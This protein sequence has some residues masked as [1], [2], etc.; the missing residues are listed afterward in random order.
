MEQ[1]NVPTEVVVKDGTVLLKEDSIKLFKDQIEEITKYSQQLTGEE[2]RKS[3]SGI[4]VKLSK[5]Q[6]EELVNIKDKIVH[7]LS[8]A[9][10][11]REILSQRA[12]FGFSKHALKR[13]LSRIE[14]LTDAEIAQIDGEKYYF[15]VHPETLEKI[16]QALI[17]SKEVE[18]YAEWKAYPYLNFNYICTFDS[19]EIK[20]TVNFQ[21]GIFIITLIVIKNTGFSMRDFF[22]NKY[23]K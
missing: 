3:V 10:K 8:P 13:V 5:Y 4:K 23:K 15:A 16:V 2:W 20:I 14:G 19:K 22:P 7:L 11:P 12:N 1:I 9:K 18:E 17:D 21:Q 6:R